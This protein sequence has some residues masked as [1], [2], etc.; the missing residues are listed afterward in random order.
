MSKSFSTL[1]DL[2]VRATFPLTRITVTMNTH[3]NSAFFL[4]EKDMR[5]TLW[6]CERTRL[7]ADNEYIVV[8]GPTNEGHQT[9]I[10]SHDIL[11]VDT[12]YC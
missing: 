4:E 8:Y 1:A 9:S 11:C 7:F 5:L 10:S 2:A 6:L 3:S 12:L